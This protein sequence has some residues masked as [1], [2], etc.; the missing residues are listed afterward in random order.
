MTL[1]V[2]PAGEPRGISNQVGIVFPSR[3][4]ERDRQPDPPQ[5]GSRDLG[6]AR[7]M[8]EEGELHLRKPSHC[9]GWW[10]SRQ[11]TVRRWLACKS[12]RSAAR[13]FTS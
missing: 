13:Y 1:G 10:S 3:R 9:K 6:V 7:Q 11:A 8:I 4:P 12:R 2:S 5:V